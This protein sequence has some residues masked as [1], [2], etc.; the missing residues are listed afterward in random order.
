MVH[1]RTSQQQL[2]NIC[3]TL[4]TQKKI[5]KADKSLGTTTCTYAEA[6]DNQWLLQW[7]ADHV[8]VEHIQAGKLALLD[9]SLLP[10]TE[11]MQLTP[12]L[13]S[14][15]LSGAIRTRAMLE[16]TLATHLQG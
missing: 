8:T 10:L 16:E 14:S 4:T 1:P 15:H 2:K 7:M 12:F 6:E 11:N 3:V 5:E 13:V 9:V